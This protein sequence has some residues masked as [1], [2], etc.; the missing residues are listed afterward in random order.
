M[1][2]ALGIGLATVNGAVDEKRRWLDA[3]LALDLVS[4]GIDDDRKPNEKSMPRGP[5][6]LKRF[7]HRINGLPLGAVLIVGPTAWREARNRLEFIHRAHS[8]ETFAQGALRAARWL[9]RQ[10]PGFYGMQDVLEL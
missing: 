5:D 3:V 4:A 2:Y 1:H 8:R 10:K 6:C 7:P 9:A